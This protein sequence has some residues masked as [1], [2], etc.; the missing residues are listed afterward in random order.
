MENV[1]AIK[2]Y[3]FAIDVTLFDIKSEEYLIMTS[4][5]DKNIEL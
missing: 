3:S 5:C 4:W 1:F 2:K